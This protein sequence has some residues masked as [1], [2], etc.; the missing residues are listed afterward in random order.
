MHILAYPPFFCLPASFL[1][2]LIKKVAPRPSGG[3]GKG[4]RKESP[5]SPNAQGSF[6]LTHDERDYESTF[7]VYIIH[8][9]K[10]SKEEG[11][12]AGK[13]LCDIDL[14]EDSSNNFDIINGK[15]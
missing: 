7:V 8:L 13:M 5:I 9:Y 6:C 1:K 2:C 11:G 14:F 10:L 4:I 12:R 15:I 3:E